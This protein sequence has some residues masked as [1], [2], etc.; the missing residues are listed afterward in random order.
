MDGTDGDTRARLTRIEALYWADR[1]LAVDEANEWLR[2]LG[3]G[4]HGATSRRLDLVIASVEALRGEASPSVATARHLLGWAVEHGDLAVQA[5]CH[6]LLSSAFETIGDFGIALE[7]AVAANDLLD[8]SEEP[9]MRAAARLCLADALS[10]AESYAESQRRY[11][12]ALQLVSDDDATDLHYAILNNSAFSY[13]LA[14]DQAAALAAVDRLLRVS[15]ASGLP[16]EMHARDTVARV[17]LAAGRVAEA[18]QV[19]APAMDPLAT[20]SVPESIAMCLIA[21]AEVY[22]TQSEFGRAQE[23]IDHC[24]ELIRNHELTRW[25]TEAAR[26]QAEIFAATGNFRDAF[27]AYQDFHHRFEAQSASAREARGRVLAAAFDTTEARRESA[28]YRDL[29]ERDPLTGLY[30]RRYVDEQLSL[31]LMAVRD[32]GPSLAIAMIDLDLFKR[33]NDLRS[34]EVGDDALRAVG[35]ILSRLVATVPGGVA[36]RMGG[37]EF[38]LILPGTDEEAADAL[39]E[40]VRLSIAEHDWQPITAGLSVTVSIGVAVAPTDGHRRSKLLGTA[41]ARLYSAKRSGRNRVVR[42]EATHTPRQ[43]RVNRGG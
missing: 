9:L 37:E 10:S 40:A 7:H 42:S 1:D 26:E 18:E 21:L 5:R 2:Q 16:I 41:D 6:R 24:Q 20:D 39:A 33:V 38:L 36:A 22:R 43:G 13:F 23:A 15:A 35:H 34:H 30:N 27:E 3:P 28:R 8:E 4:D 11:A 17:Y 29:A 31:S 32:G 14:R 12:E 19:L 25:A